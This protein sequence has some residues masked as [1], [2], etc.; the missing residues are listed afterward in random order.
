VVK[1]REDHIK[2][3]LEWANRLQ[4]GK[5]SVDSE[6]LDADVDMEDVSQRGEGAA[7]ANIARRFEFDESYVEKQHK[8]S[9]T[10]TNFKR[11]S[12]TDFSF[13]KRRVRVNAVDK[14]VKEYQLD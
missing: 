5:K 10:V 13:M 12:N 9:P 7:A 3:T 14:H 8:N 11:A 4:A 2:R 6:D 1:K